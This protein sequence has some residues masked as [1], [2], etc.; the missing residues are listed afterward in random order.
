MASLVP[1]SF[2]ETQL[3]SPSCLSIF[4]VILI[5]IRCIR[6]FD[7]PDI[8]TIVLKSLQSCALLPFGI[9][10]NT[11]SKV[12]RDVSCFEYLVNQSCHYFYTFSSVPRSSSA[13]MLSYTAGLYFLADP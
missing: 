3:L 8:I 12:F 4:G 11:F 10:T 6:T 13:E 5:C 7:A 1:F 9:D 2:S